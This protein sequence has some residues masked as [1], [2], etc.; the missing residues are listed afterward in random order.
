MLATGTGAGFGAT[1]DLKD[2]SGGDSSIDKFFDKAS[3][4]A[5]I[6]LLAFVFTAISSI[7]SSLSLPKRG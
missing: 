5:S 7:L 1:I 3:A 4:A 6:L 2:A